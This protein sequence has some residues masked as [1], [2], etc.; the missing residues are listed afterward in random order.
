M[1]ATIVVSIHISGFKL[2]ACMLVLQQY[3]KS[4]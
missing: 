4:Y 1:P 3:T 2:A